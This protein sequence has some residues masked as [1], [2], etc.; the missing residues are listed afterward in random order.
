MAREGIKAAY[1]QVRAVVA[2]L[3][4][5]ADL[6]DF[7]KAVRRTTTELAERLGVQVTCEVGGLANLPV[8][9]RQHVLAIVQ[10]ALINAHWHGHARHV[11]VRLKTVEKDAAVEVTDDGGGFDP[12]TVPREG[13]YGLAIMEERAQMAGGQLGLD[14]APGR[15]TCVTVRLPGSAP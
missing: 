1:R 6:E 8:S 3:R 13:R 11:T 12:G 9:S 7:G 14:S 15:G 2:D 10:E 4:Q 5:Q